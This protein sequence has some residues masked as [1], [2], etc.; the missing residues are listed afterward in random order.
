[1]PYIVSR[2]LYR[3]KVER[4]FDEELLSQ[5]EKNRV[6]VE[7]LVCQF[8]RQPGDTGSTPVQSEL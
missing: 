5:A 8:Q 1:M 7:K 4:V 3:H 6:K 2:D